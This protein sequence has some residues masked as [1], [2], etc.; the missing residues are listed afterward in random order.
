MEPT[1]SRNHPR[2]CDT[3]STP[4]RGPRT[5]STRLSSLSTGGKKLECE[6]PQLSNRPVPWPHSATKGCGDF[7]GDPSFIPT[8][9]ATSQSNSPQQAKL[10]TQKALQGFLSSF[11]RVSKFTKKGFLNRG[12]GVRIPPGLPSFQGLTANPFLPATI[13]GYFRGQPAPA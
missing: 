7:C 2:N 10:L 3:K 12:S 4:I 9:F 5:Y 8:H 11:Q 13:S 6:V 1:A